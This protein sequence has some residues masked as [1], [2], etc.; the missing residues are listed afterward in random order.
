M[1]Y[2]LESQL[3]NFQFNESTLKRNKIDAPCSNLQRIVKVKREKKDLAQFCTYLMYP[4]TVRSPMKRAKPD[5]QT[6]ERPIAERA[7]SKN[8]EEIAPPPSKNYLHM[9]KEII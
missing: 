3:I 5:H 7:Q 8:A 2:Q 1:P 6:P 4:A 9:L